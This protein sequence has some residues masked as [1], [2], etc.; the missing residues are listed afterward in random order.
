MSNAYFLMG[1]MLDRILSFDSIPYSTQ[2][3]DVV[4]EMTLMFSMIYFRR[5]NES[6]SYKKYFFVVYAHLI[7]IRSLFRIEH[8]WLGSPTRSMII[9]P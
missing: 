1:E 4:L 8:Q 9:A 5:D 7:R 2:T 6:I 3:H